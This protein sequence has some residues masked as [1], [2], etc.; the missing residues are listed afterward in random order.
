MGN[1]KH[2]SR[3]LSLVLRH[4][5]GNFGLAL[6]SEG[7]ATLEA[8]WVVLHKDYR[9]SATQADFDQLMSQTNR[10]EIA[11]GKIRA[12]YGHG[13]VSDIDYP[14][15]EPPERLYHG[16]VAAAL[17]S[18]RREGLTSQ[19]RQYVHLSTTL[20][21]ASEVATRRGTAIILTIR[22]LEAHRAGI[23]FHNPEPKHYL[24]RSIPPEFIDFP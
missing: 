12:L 1:S 9:G 13:D 16:T 19:A 4:K 24:A 21:R 17:D 23:I 20:D 10:F 8:V 3:F 2:L 18:I 14:A 7:F 5:A 6:D 15:A 22:A 11:N